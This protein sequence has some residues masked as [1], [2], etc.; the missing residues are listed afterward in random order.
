VSII[1]NK[2]RAFCNDEEF[3]EEKPDY[4]EGRQTIEYRVK[5]DEE[6]KELTGAYEEK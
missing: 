6:I 2:L 3:N 1:V 5:S 4:E